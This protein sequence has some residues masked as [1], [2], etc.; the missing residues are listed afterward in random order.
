MIVIGFN[1]PVEHDNAVA[2]IQDGKLVFAAEEERFSRHKHS[3]NE[4]PVGALKEA[5]K[6]LKKQGIKPREV[7][8]YAINYDPKLYSLKMRK[9]IYF[10]NLK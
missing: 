3:P 9:H 5:F 10:H 7:E 4:P 6:F 8:A 2:I 1:W